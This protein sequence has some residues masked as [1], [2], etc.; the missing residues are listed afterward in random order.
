MEAEVGLMGEGAGVAVTDLGKEVLAVTLCVHPSEG[1]AFRA[2]F[3]GA[4]GFT[5]R[6]FFDHGDRGRFDRG[7]R[8][9]RFDRDDRFLFR[10]NFFVGFDFAA[11]GFPGLA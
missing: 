10:R 4:R 8:F 2:G 1:A 3:I 9:G 6:G 5:D 7:D 11:F